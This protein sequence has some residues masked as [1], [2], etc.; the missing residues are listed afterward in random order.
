MPVSP[1]RL[2]RIVLPKINH[3]KRM[4]RHHEPY[5]DDSIKRDHPFYERH[6][7]YKQE[8]HLLAVIDLHCIKK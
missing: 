4:R 8:I 3:V 5:M 1:T 2:D 7:Q 6:L